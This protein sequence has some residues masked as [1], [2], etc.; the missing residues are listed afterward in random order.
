MPT[1]SPSRSNQIYEQKVSREYQGM[2][3]GIGIE[4]QRVGL[5]F[6]DFV[7]LLTSNGY[8]KIED[9]DLLNCVF[10]MATGFVKDIHAG[11]GQKFQKSVPLM[12]VDM[13]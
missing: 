1:I 6:D 12:Q 2:V 5:I 7:Q 9:V 13:L 3:A 8:A 10:H 11:T 4:K